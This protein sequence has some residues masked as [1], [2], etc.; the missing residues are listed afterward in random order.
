[1]TARSGRFAKAPSR[2][3]GKPR[4]GF[5]KLQVVRNGPYV[6]CL[7]FHSSATDPETGERLDRSLYYAALIN[8]AAVG[9]ISPSP[10][11]E[12]WMIWT[13]GVQITEDEYEHMLKVREWALTHEPTDPAANPNKPIDLDDLPSL[14]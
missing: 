5:F 3:I 8:G 11:D 2:E 14:I 10:S 7:I 12:V 6:P 4:P 1:M 9:D 13:H